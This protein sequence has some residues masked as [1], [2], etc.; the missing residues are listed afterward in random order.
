M[1]ASSLTNFN[2]Q[3]FRRR[4]VIALWQLLPAASLWLLLLPSG[5]PKY[6]FALTEILPP[7]PLLAIFYWGLA[8]PGK[9]GLPLVFVLGLVQDALLTTPF[10]STAMLWLLFRYLV[11]RQRKDI[12]EEGFVAT[13]AACAGLLLVALALQWLLMCYYFRGP[14]PVLPV[15]MQWLLGVLCYPAMH[16]L[17]HRV[18]RMFHRRYWFILKPAG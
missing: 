8:R 14:M 11:M 3:R 18:E 4:R 2:H 13:W 10:G 5:L 12:A 1:S 7:L 16:A 9:I 17:F 15:F 6:A